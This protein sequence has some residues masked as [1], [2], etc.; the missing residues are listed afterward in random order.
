MQII[1]CQYEQQSETI[2]A[3]F[4]HAIIHSTALYE[5]HPRTLDDIKQWFEAKSAHKFPVIGVI[6]EN[7]QL[8]G[9]A[10][11]GVF[12]P[13]PAN[14]FTAE[15][16]IYVDQQHHGK[17]VATQLMTTLIER[18]KSQGLHTII[19]AID[20]Q[21]QASIELHKKFGFI[22]TGTLK[23]VGFKFEKWLNLCFYQ[24]MLT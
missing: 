11:Y 18:A 7:N 10:S 22:H 13:Y 15:L 16:A 4:N 14:K 19:A 21:N 17:G 2:L 24:L 20:E 8:L 1:D 3:L 12:R 9:F 5:Y 23:E 6:D